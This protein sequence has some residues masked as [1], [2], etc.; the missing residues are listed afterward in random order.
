M[1]SRE[2]EDAILLLLSLDGSRAQPENAAEALRAEAE[3]DVQLDLQVNSSST[4]R[5]LPEMQN[6]KGLQNDK[7]KHKRSNH[8]MKKGEEG[9][10]DDDDDDDD[11]D[12]NNNKHPEPFINTI[13][14]VVFLKADRATVQQT[15][16]NMRLSAQQCDWA[17]VA[18]SG[19]LQV[20]NAQHTIRTVQRLVRNTKH[21]T[22]YVLYTESHETQSISH[23]EKNRIYFI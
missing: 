13:L 1:D 8:N 10:D 5:R 6:R 4:H 12:N 7:E 19:S 9:K 22:Q 14:C 18:Y 3:E 21:D 17:V 11:D 15:I 23:T 20:Q 2:H 16:F